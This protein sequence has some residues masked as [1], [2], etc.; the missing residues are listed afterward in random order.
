[1]AKMQE[2]P[3]MDPSE[4]IPLFYPHVAANAAQYVAEVLSTR[5]IGQGPKVDEFEQKFS[6]HIGGSGYYVA[7]N[8]G[9]AALH[10]AYILAGVK[11]GSEVI[12]PIF[13]CTATNIPIMYQKGIPV[14]VDIAEGTLNVD[15]NALE[16]SI[17]A[18]TVAV[19]VVD[20]G[21]L[22]NDYSVLREIC[23]RHGLS[24]IVDCAHA[25]DTYYQDTHV[26]GYADYVIYS[27]QAIK[28][29][30]TG[31]GGMLVVRKEVDYEKARLLR[32]FGIDRTKKQLGI[33]ENDLTELGYKYQMSDITA[34]I[35][36]ASLEE[37]KSVL[38]KRRDL[39]Q[40][41]QDKL[42]EFAE[43][44][45][46]RPRVG[47]NFTPWLVTLNT[48]GRRLGLMKHL[49]EKNIESAQVHYRNDIYSIF[50]KYSKGPYANMD[51]IEDHYLVLPFH[52]KLSN[53]QIGRICDEVKSFLR[54]Y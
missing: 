11:E 50:K 27:F 24:L 1:M 17:T 31:D 20:Y 40:I 19:C 22:P 13:T 39:Y 15:L 52:T 7:V 44:L 12:C 34:A 29:M 3:L 33:W 6:K 49:K 28:T 32:W 35:G 16:Q 37:L 18:K 46:E 23:D 36:L 38:Q 30:T 48:K 4:G 26:T 53:D 10:L 51:K 21:G 42:D 2:F 5:W 54:T 45:F 47:V 41:Y 9:T 43:C 14:F 8:S 25:V